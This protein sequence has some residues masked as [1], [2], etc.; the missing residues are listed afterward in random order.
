MI[1]T[2]NGIIDK[3]YTLYIHVSPNGKMYVGITSLKP[4]RGK[5]VCY[6]KILDN[7]VKV[8]AK[9]LVGLYGNI[10]RCVNETMA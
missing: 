8:N 1:S 4:E 7:V 5:L 2:M 9:L 10:R 6:I 3:K